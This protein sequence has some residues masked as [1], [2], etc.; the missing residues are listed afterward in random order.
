MQFEAVVELGGT[1]DEV[2]SGFTD[3]IAGLTPA[4]RAAVLGG[5]MQRIYGL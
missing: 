4:E 3:L 2:W 5:A 1:F